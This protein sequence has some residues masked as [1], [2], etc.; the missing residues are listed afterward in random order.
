MHI[1]LF[2]D[3]NIAYLV[4]LCSVSFFFFFFFFLSYGS[5]PDRVILSP[6]SSISLFFWLDINRGSYII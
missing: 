1:F 3:V 5:W 6:T 4:I 2:E